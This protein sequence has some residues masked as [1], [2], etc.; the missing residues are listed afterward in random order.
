[1]QNGRIVI[2]VLLAAI[3]APAVAAP[4][5]PEA[6]NRQFDVSLN[7][8]IDYN[9]NLPRVS[10]A[11]AKA[12][13]LVLE[14]TTYVPSV[15]LDLRLPIGRQA[16]FAS[17]SAG[18][19]YHE[20][21]S[22][23]DSE[24]VALTAGFDTRLGP[25]RNRLS[26][27]YQSSLSDLQDIN[28]ASAVTDQ[29]EIKTAGLDVKCARPTGLGVTFGATE[30]WTSHDLTQLAQQESRS[31]HYTAG[32]TYGRPALGNLTLFGSYGRTKFPRRPLISGIEPGYEVNAGGLT[33]DRHLGARIEG[34]VTISYSEVS[35]LVIDP[36][37]PVKDFSGATY[38][39]DLQYRPAPR[40][41]TSLSFQ[42]QVE[43]SNRLG[44]NYDLRTLYRLSGSYELGRRIRLTLGVERSDSDS[45][46]GSAV[47]AANLLTK[48]RTNSAFGGI[49]YDLSR[50]V[51]VNLDARQEERKTNNAR[52]NYD[53][54]NVALSVHLKY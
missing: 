5:Q 48:S 19:D 2:G 50:R 8:R 30:T 32:L 15:N 46:G 25:C 35:Q 18:Y 14:D 21:N 54:T 9:T 42:R 3:A 53:D 49:G 51:G 39:A 17:G 36:A 28:L 29:L 34:T 38:S 20:S 31:E 16:F 41:S 26:G 47:A 10:E 7:A 44:N 43:P 12:R 27:S 45:S 33:Y 11:E 1:M 23:L 13:H 40:L 22:Q 37:F 52:Y 4:R 6:N 24:R